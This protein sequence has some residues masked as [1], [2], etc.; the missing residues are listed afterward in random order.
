MPTPVQ[1]PVQP[2]PDSQSPVFPPIPP[3]PPPLMPQTPPN[4]PEPLRLPDVT[5]ALPPDHEVVPTPT[6]EQPGQ[7]ESPGAFSSGICQ[8]DGRCWNECPHWK[9]PRP[10]AF[11]QYGLD[12]GGWVQQGTTLNWDRPSDH[13][14]GPMTPNDRANEYQLNQAWL[15]AVRTPNMEDNWLDVGGRI[16]LSFGT[17]WRFYSGYGLE[18][19]INGNEYGLMIPQMYVDVA[20]NNLTVRMGRFATF[21]GYEAVPSTLN[22]F[23]SHAYCNSFCFDP[24]LVTGLMT[25]FKIGENWVVLNGFH[26]GELMFDDINGDLNYLGGLK[27]AGDAKQTSFSAMVDTGNEDPAGTQNRTNLYLLF[28]QRLGCSLQYALQS[29]LG[30]QEGASVAT[31]G[32]DAEWY[33]LSQ[34]LIYSF[35]PQWSVGA[36][37]E[38]MRDD[39]GARVYGAGKALGSSAASMLSP[40]FAGNF[41]D[42]TFG[43]NWRPHPN[44][45]VRHEIRWDWYNGTPNIDGLKPYDNGSDRSQLTTA[46]D[47][48]VTF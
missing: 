26:R 47:L 13:F 15:Y 22:F 35:N 8:M 4:R 1:P 5:D 48:I 9:I 12:F 25:E 36:R 28:T 45:L 11:D 16:D 43:T 10:A 38:W 44:I 42:L 39:D 17:D 31:P 41:Y 3:V 21:T 27:W 46:M 32:N 23:Y 24:L 29:T 2:P 30:R 20:W 37:F 7:T 14:N 33:G 18:D 34:W 6:P 40:G 19:R